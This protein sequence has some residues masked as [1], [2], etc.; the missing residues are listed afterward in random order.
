MIRFFQFI[1]KYFKMDKLNDDICGRVHNRN[2]V[3]AEITFFRQTHCV[4][5][6]VIR[7]FDFGLSLVLMVSR[8][9]FNFANSPLKKGRKFSSA[10]FSA[11]S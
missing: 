9:V 7:Y 4:K 3:A 5:Q 2:W 10:H 1:F 6:R 11:I 8:K